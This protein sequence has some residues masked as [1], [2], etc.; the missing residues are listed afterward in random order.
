MVWKDF[1][2]LPEGF[3]QIY[4]GF[5]QIFYTDSTDL[6][7]KTVVKIHLEDIVGNK[8]LILKKYIFINSYIFNNKITSKYR[9]CSLKS[10]CISHAFTSFV[11]EVHAS[12]N[13]M[14]LPI[15]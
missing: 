3:I 4:E 13:S 10:A 1:S 12:K 5:I 6:R 14:R 2:R 8:R 11:Y 9:K 15:K 7:V